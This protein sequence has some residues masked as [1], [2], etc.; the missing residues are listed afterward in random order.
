MPPSI[1]RSIGLN[2]L[3]APAKMCDIERL[4][5]NPWI[6]MMIVR[7]R[8]DHILNCAAYFRVFFRKK[9]YLPVAEGEAQVILG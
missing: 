7:L 1:H 6:L 8:N 2:L 9:E 4:E 5:S 3:Q